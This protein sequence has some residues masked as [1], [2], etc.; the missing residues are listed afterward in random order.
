[1]EVKRTHNGTLWQRDK[2][3]DLFKHFSSTKNSPVPRK[4]QINIVSVLEDVSI[5]SQKVLVQLKQ[6]KTDPF[7]KGISILIFATNNIVCPVAAMHQY[8]SSQ[9]HDGS[10]ALYFLIC[11]AVFENGQLQVQR[12]FF[13]HQAAATCAKLR[14]EDHLIKTL[15]RWSSDCYNSYIHTE[16]STLRDVQLS[17]SK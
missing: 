2:I 3:Q 4:I 11:Y 12:P 13:A 5:D 7:R 6:S 1:M 8:L 16:R 17:M 10:R 9:T 14:I 15:G